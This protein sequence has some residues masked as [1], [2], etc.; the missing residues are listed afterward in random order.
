MLTITSS[1][2]LNT[3]NLAKDINIVALIKVMIINEFLIWFSF[4]FQKEPLV[5]MRK[6]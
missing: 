4:F 2:F 3:I 1:A 6:Q 5:I